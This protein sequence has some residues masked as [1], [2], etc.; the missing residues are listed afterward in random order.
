MYTHNAFFP[1]YVN[2]HMHLYIYGRIKIYPAS[3]F[4]FVLIDVNCNLH[5]HIYEILIL[6]LSYKIFYKSWYEKFT[7]WFS[8][9]MRSWRN[10]LWNTYG[11]M[12]THP[13]KHLT[14]YQQIWNAARIVNIPQIIIFIS[15]VW[16]AS[17]KNYWI[18]QTTSSEVL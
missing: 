10:M 18:Q 6:N 11:M 1:V 2:T 3:S 17:V 4:L 8:D 16:L 9:K 13:M 12:H 7:H 14:L 5:T 15:A